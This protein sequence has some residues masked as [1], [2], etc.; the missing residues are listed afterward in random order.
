MPSHGVTSQGSTLP[1]QVA[2]ALLLAGWEACA[3]SRDG[4]AAAHPGGRLSLAGRAQLKACMLACT[5]TAQ[6]A[7]GAYMG[8]PGAAGASSH[9][10]EGLTAAP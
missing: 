6:G 2:V 10:G 8:V 5:G 7:P 4:S 9:P 1:G 3:A